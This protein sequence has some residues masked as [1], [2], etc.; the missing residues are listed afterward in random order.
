MNT[1]VTSKEAILEE[2]R[3]IVMEQGISAVNMRSVAAAC[4]VAVGS[5]YNYFPS[6]TDLISAA[7]EDVWK[8]IFHMSGD[9][10]VFDCFTDCLEWLFESIR[11]GC[12]KYP[13]FF[14]LHS[15]SFAAED[16]A[17]GRRM[18]EQYFGHIKQNLKC[19]LGRDSEVRADAF[20]G[21]F[22]QDEFVDLIFITLTSMLLQ[23]RERCGPL[24]EMASRCIY[25]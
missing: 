16:K 2:C 3:K 25:Q 24:L 1:V 10:S 9:F 12:G 20:H 23:G 21:G 15:M 22:T 17:S 5:I 13:G 6:K 14:T 11:K 18:M 7:V 4:G 8:D 19:V